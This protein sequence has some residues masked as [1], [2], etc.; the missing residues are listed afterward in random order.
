[1]CFLLEH[2]IVSLDSSNLKLIG[3]LSP[4]ILPRPLLTGGGLTGPDD[5]ALVGILSRATNAIDPA[6]RA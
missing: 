3:G 2:R 4:E 6:T 1:M 5:Y